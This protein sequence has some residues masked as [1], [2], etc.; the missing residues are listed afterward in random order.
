LV[1]HLRKQ[2]VESFTNEIALGFLD[3]NFEIEL[4]L[5]QSY[6]P[7]KCIVAE[8]MPTDIELSGFPV[9]VSGVADEPPYFAQCYPLPTALRYHRPQDLREQCR[10][11]AQTIVMGY[12]DISELIPKKMSPISRQV[13]QAIARFHQSTRTPTPVIVCPIHF[14]L[15]STNIEIL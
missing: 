11:H 12:Q 10:S 8:F 5:G 9:I 13:L 1:S 15:A 4:T 3:H 14:W 2:A 7:M 6:K